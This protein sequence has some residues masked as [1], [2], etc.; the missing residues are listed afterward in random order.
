MRPGQ[1]SQ[2]YFSFIE[3]RIAKSQATFRSKFETANIE[4]EYAGLYC[5]L[6]LAHEPDEVGTEEA[7][8]YLKQ[9]YF[10]DLDLRP[11]NDE[12]A[13]RT[14]VNITVAKEQESELPG[15]SQQAVHAEHLTEAEK[16]LLSVNMFNDELDRRELQLDELNEKFFVSVFKALLYTKNR[17]ILYQLL[18]VIN[19]Y[20][21]HETP[22]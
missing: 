18:D 3:E 4:K 21:M 20:I 5:L 10:P 22:Y 12:A 16:R 13:Q 15:E 19:F 9:F 2:I 8:R 17:R 6:R 7:A 1:Q 11:L 14:G